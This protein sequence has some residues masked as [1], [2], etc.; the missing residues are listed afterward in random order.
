MGEKNFNVLFQSIYKEIENKKNILILPHITPDGDAIAS[1]LAFSYFIQ[2]LNKKAIVFSKNPPKYLKYLFGFSN[3]QT[4]SKN[5]EWFKGVELIIALDYADK[6]RL[7]KFF[8]NKN[9]TIITL[10]HHPPQNQIGEIKIIDSCA[11]STSEIIFNFFKTINFKINKNLA[12]ILLTGIYTDSVCFA[13]LSKEKL[14]IIQELISLGANLPQIAKNYLEFDIKKA[15]LL[16]LVLQRLEKRGSII[17][18]WL[19][20]GEASDIVFNE[21]PIFPDFISFIDK[22]DAYIFLSKIEENQIK[23][24]LRA[25]RK[26][27]GLNIVELAEKFGGGGHREATGF[28]LRAKSIKEAKKIIEKELKI[29]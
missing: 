5:K 27:N 26:K 3:I 12:T 29:K 24:S 22:A 11:S 19:K 4:K 23:V 7:P 13:R 1:A 28:I 20:E 14:S 6:K 2:R 15:K 21:T 16:S 8:I 17:F 9:I 18:S 10:D 25:P